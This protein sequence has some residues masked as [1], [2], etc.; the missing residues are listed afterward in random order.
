LLDELPTTV[1]PCG[2]NGEFHTFVFDGPGFASAV[3]FTA[4][5][6]REESPFAFRDLLPA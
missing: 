5:A 6:L 2:E 4:G 3:A 1:D